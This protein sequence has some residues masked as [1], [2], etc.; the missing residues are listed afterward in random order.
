VPQ[1]S[2]QLGYERVGEEHVAGV[3]TLGD[4]GAEANSSPRHAILEDVADI[5]P[6]DLGKAQ[7]GAEGEGEEHVVARVTSR[8]LEQGSLFAGSQS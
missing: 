5:E 2:A 8:G 7:S 3:A 1:E 4:L 6:Y